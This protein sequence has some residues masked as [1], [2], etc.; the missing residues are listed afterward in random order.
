M[1]WTGIPKSALQ[2]NFKSKPFIYR[3][4]VGD[5]GVCISERTC[6]GNCGC[7]ISLHYFLYSDKI[8]VAATT[9][10]QSEFETPQVGC[11]IWIRQKPSWYTIPEDGVERHQE[12]DD[13]GKALVQNYLDHGEK[14]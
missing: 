5:T 6:C 8:H 12:F 11:H 13:V 2:W 9:V 14:V 7:N 4:T 1:A 10:Q 3:P